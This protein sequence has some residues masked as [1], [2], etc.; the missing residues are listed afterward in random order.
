MSYDGSLKFDTK[1]DHAGFVSGIAEI[2]STAMAAITAIGGAFATGAIAKAII[3]QISALEEYG[4]TINDQAQKLTV[5]KK[6]YQE[7][8]YMMGQTGGSADTLQM[9]IKTLSSAVVDGNKAFEKLGISL[10]D[11]RA[12]SSEDL[13]N[14]VITQL[15]GMEE[16]TLRTSLAADLFG[17]SATE[18]NPLLNLGAEGIAKMR[19]EAA[20][21]GLVMSDQAVAATD[22]YGDATELAKRAAEGLRNTMLVGMLPTLTNVAKGFADIASKSSQAFSE[23]G[24]KG[25]V[26]VITDEFPVATATVSGLAAAFVSLLVIQTL[27][28]VVGGFIATE[29][30]LTLATQ[31]GTL[32]QWNELG[33]LSAKHVVV[34][35][36]TGKLSVATAAQWL[37]NAAIS[38]NP[39]MIL[40]AGVGLLVG[41][42][43]LLNKQYEKL[44]PNAERAIDG[45]DALRQE[46][47]SSSDAFK[48][49]TEEIESQ[50]RGMMSL[51]D[52]LQSMSAEYSGTGIEQ[53]KMQSIVDELNGG[54]EGLNLTFDKQTGKLSM[55][56]DAV[57]ELAQAQYDAAQSTATLSRYT[58]LLEEQADAEYAVRVARK[59]FYE[60]GDGSGATVIERIKLN[61]ALRDAIVISEGV[62]AEIE[63]CNAQLEQ[64]GTISSEVDSS[65]NILGF[66]LGEVAGAQSRIIIGGVDVTDLLTATG[67]SATDAADRLNTFTGAATNMFEKINTK[68]Q[69][70]AR[71]LTSTLDW[72]T[73]AM[74]QYG[75]DMVLLAGQLPQD[76][77]DAFSANPADVAGTVRNLAKASPEDLAALSES[78]SAAGDTAREAWL[79]SLGAGTDAEESPLTS[80]AEAVKNDTSLNDA[81]SQAVTDGKDAMVTAASEADYTEVTTAM[82]DGLMLGVNSEDMKATFYA[83]GSA[84]TMQWIKG[85]LSR[86]QEFKDDAKALANAVNAAFRDA[87]NLS[88]PTPS[89]G[90]SSSSGSSSKSGG[91]SAGGAGT[92]P[93][94]A[95]TFSAGLIV[96]AAKQAT[97]AT[98]NS[99]YNTSITVQGV[100][101]SDSK[102]AKR[103]T[104]QFQVVVLYGR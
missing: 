1:V 38:A 92:R 18:L 81:M 54:I 40:V 53:R 36:L 23:R 46:V 75:D 31:F 37:W 84:L 56:A 11:A 26:D 28:K 17:R 43:V 65:L 95:Q 63:D 83:S 69:D 33:A 98:Y 79:K 85:M 71:S 67:E 14:N 35:L 22:E 49:S 52:T 9:G 39:V 90:V 68:S 78:W 88:I 2:K 29:N 16:G 8:S 102:L 76:M 24:V 99:T 66:R 13:F 41:S 12:M 97:A 94:I 5:S 100:V 82:K 57:R 27:Q 42:L 45:V 77:L 86:T 103:V 61:N 55:N 10:E 50:R 34:G 96:T 87:L 30:L 72:N 15:A 48:S 80:V 59:A 51:V 58:K 4:S 64:Q 93:D 19:K 6:A 104:S 21:Y 20:D 89:F 62:T 60:A 91:G 25:V 7:L 73:D 3:G 32:A 70:T 44:H 47:D 101:E 74:R